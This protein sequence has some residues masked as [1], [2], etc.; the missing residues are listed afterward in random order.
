MPAIRSGRCAA[1]ARAR[2][3]RAARRAATLRI[4]D[5]RRL[6]VLDQHLAVAE[7][8]V[9]EQRRPLARRR[10]TIAQRR[11]RS[12]ALRGRQPSTSASRPQ[13]SSSPSCAIISR[14]PTRRPARRRSRARRLSSGSRKRWPPARDQQA[15]ERRDR[16]RRRS[17][18]SSCP[19]RGRLSS[20]TLPPSRSTWSL[21]IA[22]PSPCPETSVITKLVLRPERKTSA[23]A[24][25]SLARR[26]DPRALGR[27]PG[28]ARGRCRGR[29]RSSVE[30]DAAA[31][32]RPHASR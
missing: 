22:R 31:L 18:G 2:R 28:R 7:H 4:A 16:R 10:S 19:A 26:R 30:L 20:S 23:S 1:R 32:E 5:Q 12:V 17:A 9:D 29:R 11:A 8:L 13:G 6:E 24:S 14:P 27:R 25:S 3:R 15:A 21:T